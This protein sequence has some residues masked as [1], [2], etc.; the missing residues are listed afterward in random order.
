MTAAFGLSVPAS[1]AQ[2]MQFAQPSNHW[3]IDGAA[4]GR[5]DPGKVDTSDKNYRQQALIPK[6][7][8]THGGQDTGI[9]ASGPKAYLIGGVVEQNN[10]FHAIEHFRLKLNHT[11]ALIFCFYALLIRKPVPTIREVL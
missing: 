3:Y 9:Y 5:T 4:A 7:S 2:T 6:K 11:N 1:A 8:E 10:I